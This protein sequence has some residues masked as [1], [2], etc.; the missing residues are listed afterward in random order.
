M[1]LKLIKTQRDE[2]RVSCHRFYLKLTVV[3]L[4]KL[5]SMQYLAFPFLCQGKETIY[6]LVAFPL[7]FLIP[8]VDVSPKVDDFSGISL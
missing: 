1:K 2:F 4:E 5:F 6:S 8:R 3:H 7:S